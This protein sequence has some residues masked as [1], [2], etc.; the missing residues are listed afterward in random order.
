MPICTCGKAFDTTGTKCLECIELEWKGKDDAAS[1]SQD[2]A[3]INRTN[4]VAA[5]VAEVLTPREA[6]ERDL[7]SYHFAVRNLAR[8][9]NDAERPDAIERIDNHIKDLA[10]KI[11]QFRIDTGAARRLKAELQTVKVAKLTPEE[12]EKYLKESRNARAL[13]SDKVAAKAVAKHQTALEKQLAGLLALGMDD[14]S[15]PVKRIRALIKG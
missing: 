11:E 9:E 4:N 1:A 15:E 7:S 13:P 2:A 5:L 6:V 12:R 14:A 8:D 10:R 3:E